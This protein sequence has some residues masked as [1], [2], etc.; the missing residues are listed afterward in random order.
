MII[1]VYYRSYCYGNSYTNCLLIIIDDE[2]KR[3]LR[4]QLRA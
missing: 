4:A 1:D 3:Q 2:S